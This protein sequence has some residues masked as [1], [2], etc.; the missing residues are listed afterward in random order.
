MTNC[1][2]NSLTKLHGWFCSLAL[3]LCACASMPEHCGDYVSIADGARCLPDNPTP[4]TYTVTYNINGGSGTTPAARTVNA[5]SVV[6]V[7]NGN[8]LSRSGY[9]FDGWNTNASGTGTNYGVGQ[10]F[11]PTGNITLYA[12][13][14]ATVSGGESGTFV[15]VRDQTSY[16]WVKIGTQTWMAEN[17]NYDVPGVTTDV[18][19]NN[20]PDSCAKYGRLYNWATVMNG[21]SSSTLSPSGVQGVCPEGWHVPSDAEWTT[22]ENFVGTTAGTKLK[23][24]SGWSHRSGGISGNGTDDFGFSA[25]PGGSRWSNSDFNDAGYDGY[26]WSATEYDATNARSRFI[27]FYEDV[28]ERYSYFK[29]ILFSL[30]C[31]R[32]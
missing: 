6:L 3:L 4:T 7:N 19:Y 27:S 18:C 13:W 15:D 11:T 14:T 20:A 29:T 16:K 31:V 21:A 24:T 25:L 9:T 12:R 1:K 23:S 22:L 10:S 28:V 30:R 5:G 2:K 17:L 32:D 26:W 8:G